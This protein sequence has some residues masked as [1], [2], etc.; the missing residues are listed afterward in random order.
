MNHATL[1][2]GQTRLRFFFLHQD[3][4]EKQHQPLLTLRNQP[5]GRLKVCSEGF[6]KRKRGRFI[7]TSP[8]L[9]DK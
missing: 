3:M 4:V 6:Q 9:T 7:H 1:F 5:N 8:I 2:T